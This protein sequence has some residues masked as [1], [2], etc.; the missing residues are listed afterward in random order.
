[1]TQPSEQESDALNRSAM[2]PHTVAFHW[3]LKGNVQHIGDVDNTACMS[4]SL[5]QH[6][7]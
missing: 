3:P 4:I 5:E 1:M 7:H 6:E 2:V